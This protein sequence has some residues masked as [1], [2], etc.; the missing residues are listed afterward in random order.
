MRNYEYFLTEFT[1]QK[2]KDGGESTPV[3]LASL[4]GHVLDLMAARC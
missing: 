1:V 2:A 3:S 4:I